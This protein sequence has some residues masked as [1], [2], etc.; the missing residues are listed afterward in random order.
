MKRISVIL[1]VALLLITA[2]ISCLPIPDFHLTDDGVGVGCYGNV[3]PCNDVTYDLGAAATRWHHTYTETTDTVNIN[4]NNQ[5]LYIDAGAGH[6]IVLSQPT[7]NDLQI[8]MSNARLPSALA[9]TYRPFFSSQVPAFSD[10]QINVLYFSAQLPHSYLEG[11]DIEF[12]I[13]VAYP[14]A[15]AGNSVWYFTY[16]WANG[17]DEFAVALSSTV[18]VA[19]P[20]VANRHQLIELNTAI[21]G[22]GKEI[23]SVLACS[24]QRTGT[25]G[26]DTYPNEI[27]LLSGDFYYQSDTLGSRTRLAK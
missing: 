25:S 22:T 9:P 4:S 19:S 18:T 27:Y 24:I 13:H 20:T 11:S 6:T 8:N 2:S 12:H 10:T 5:D 7:W 17:G 26:S 23:S 14:D 21:D 1:L 16:S 15:Q 3:V